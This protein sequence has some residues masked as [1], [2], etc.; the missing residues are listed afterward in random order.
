MSEMFKPSFNPNLLKPRAESFVPQ[1][2][3]EQ[4]TLLTNWTRAV[5][6]T[7]FKKQ[8]EK[9]HQGAF[10]VQIFGALLGY[11][12]YTANPENYNLKAETASGETKVVKPHG[13]TGILQQD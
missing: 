7:N 12:H 2:S 5:S 11:A 4:A 8:N 9:P 1:L 10:L 6:D 3:Q 13:Q